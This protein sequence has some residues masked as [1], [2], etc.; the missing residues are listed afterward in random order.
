MSV[1]A[2]LAA[3]PRGDL[4]ERW[5]EVIGHPSPPRLSRTMM[6]RILACEL[7]W[8]AT[9]QSRAAMFKRLKR[10]LE[11]AD[12]QAPIANS[13]ARLVREWNGRE[14]VVDVTDDGYIWNGKSWRSLSAIA[15]EITG[16]KWSGPRFFGVGA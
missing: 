15:K 2:E 14:H 10:A 7:Q 12:R 3:L 8:R 5:E 16:A 13:G 1:E 4:K 6:A 11:A 9:G